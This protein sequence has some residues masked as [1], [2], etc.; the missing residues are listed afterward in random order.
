MIPRKETPKN[1]WENFGCVSIKR[2]SYIQMDFRKRQLSEFDDSLLASEVTLAFWFKCQS[3]ASW[4]VNAIL[5]ELG[6]IS[7]V[8][9]LISSPLHCGKINRI[10]KQC[11]FLITHRSMDEL[12]CFKPVS[13]T[14][15]FFRNPVRKA[16]SG[17]SRWFIE[18][19]W[20][21]HN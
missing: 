19:A 16:P 1:V 21:N 12:M 2:I 20:R 4:T 8:F 7:T 13:T 11:S 5:A 18:S 17:L 15:C 6:L 14:T 9:L 3:L 10:L